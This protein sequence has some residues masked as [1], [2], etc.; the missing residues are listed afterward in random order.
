M[1]GLGKL[2]DSCGMAMT[3]SKT[4]KFLDYQGLIIWY[5]LSKLSCVFRV[6][7]LLQINAHVA[8]FPLLKYINT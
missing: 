6:T 3:I 1:V 2:I 7:D 8:G 5:S 4:V